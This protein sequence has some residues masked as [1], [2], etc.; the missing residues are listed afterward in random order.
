MEIN[1]GK[2]CTK[3]SK[4]DFLPISCD[5]CDEK[6]CCECSINHI[7][8]CSNNQTQNDKTFETNYE[9]FE[10]IK[11]YDNNGLDDEIMVNQDCCLCIIL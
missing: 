11:L 1:I 3:C 5:N 10:D 9:D 8:N 6:F 2:H 7:I 4:L